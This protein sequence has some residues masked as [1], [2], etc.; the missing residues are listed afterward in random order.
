M[1]KF[2]GGKVGTVV[3][4][5]SIRTSISGKVVL[6]LGYHSRGTWSV[7]QFPESCCSSQQ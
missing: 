2:L 4:D 1:H 5:Y 6:K 3:A 7:G